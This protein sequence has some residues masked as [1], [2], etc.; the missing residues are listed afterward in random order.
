MKLVDESVA[1]SGTTD[2][3]VDHFQHNLTFV[4]RL[5]LLDGVV[6]FFSNSS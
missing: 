6:I 4:D 5:V 2:R 3:D 1:S